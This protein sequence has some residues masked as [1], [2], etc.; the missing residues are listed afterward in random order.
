[1]GR[2]SAMFVSG[3]VTAF[4]LMLFIGLAGGS[5]WF[6]G[7]AQAAAPGQATL[8]AQLSAPGSTSASGQSSADVATLEKEVAAYKTQLQQS[9]DQLQQAYNQIAT[10]QQQ[11]QT[12]QQR[13]FRGGGSSPFLGGNDD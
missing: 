9:Y 8:Q 6:M 13:R 4:L 12:G 7:T 2:N 3:I 10:L 5:R 1:M 11:V